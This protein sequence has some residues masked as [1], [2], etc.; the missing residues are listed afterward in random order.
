MNDKV[1]NVEIEKLDPN[2]FQVRTEYS[3]ADLMA[4]GRSIKD[5]GLLEPIIVRPKN[6]HF[7]ICVGERRSRACRLVNVR[8]IQAIVKTLSDEDMAAYGLIENLQRKDLNSIE[9]AKGFKKLKEQFGWSQSNIARETGKTR[10]YIAQRL[11]LLTFPSGLQD[12]VSHDTIT[13]THAEALAILADEPNLLENSITKVISQKLTTKQT[14]Q[15]VQDIKRKLPLKKRIMEYLMSEQFILDFHYIMNTIN[16]RDGPTFC[17]LSNCN[18]DMIYEELPKEGR[19]YP[20]QRIVC[21]NCGWEYGI[22]YGPLWDLVEYID[23]MKESK[24][25]EVT[26]LSIP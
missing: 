17:P 20:D 7:E 2:P 21:Q 25:R 9:E 5:E 8:N 26:K 23:E 15:L 10:D 1:I 12:L 16:A 4:L 19:K 24:V 14:E 11:R 3:E 22:S 18:G 6:D 13:P